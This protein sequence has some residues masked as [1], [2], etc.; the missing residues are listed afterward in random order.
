M[1]LL[2]LPVL[3]VADLVPFSIGRFM[4]DTVAAEATNSSGPRKRPPASVLADADY[5]LL[6]FIPIAICVALL[7][8]FAF[9]F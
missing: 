7:T 5:W 8:Y 4:T 1:Q 2:E 9:A 3:G 6:L